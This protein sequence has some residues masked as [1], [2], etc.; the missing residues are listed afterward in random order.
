MSVTQ[1]VMVCIFAYGQTGSGKTHTMLGKPGDH[2]MIPRAMDFLFATSNAMKAQGWQF[3]MRAAMLEIYN[4]EYKDLLGRGPPNGK[5]HSVTHSAQSTT[6]SYLEWVDV[7]KPQRVASLLASAMQQRA[8]GATAVNEHSSRSHFVFMLQIV[9]TNEAQGTEVHGQLNLIDL[10][11][12]ERLKSS[13]ATGDRLKETQ[14]INKSLSAL[15]DVIMAL[16]NKEQHVPYRNSKLTYLLQQS[17]GGD[18]KTL[19]FVNIAP[20]L[21]SAQESL[22]SLRFAAKVNSCE[23]GVAKKNVSTLSHSRTISSFV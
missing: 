2:G 21:E 18:A 4:E 16:A 22:C 20:S 23:I 10:A 17:L 7:S 1:A 19:M 9:G 12:S 13:L 5:K 6:V 3:E 11:G 8:V 14:N 15:G